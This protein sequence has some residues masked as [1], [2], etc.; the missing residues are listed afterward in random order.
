M[1]LLVGS[2]SDA[3][4]I[5]MV[6]AELRPARS[7]L[8]LRTTC[9]FAKKE[10]PLQA[11]TFYVVDQNSRRLLFVVESASNR[12][13]H[14]VPVR[15]SLGIR[16][17]ISLK[18]AFDLANIVQRRGLSDVVKR[19]FRLAGDHRQQAPDVIQLQ[20]LPERIYVGAKIISEYAVGQ[21][22]HD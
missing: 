6:T 22:T 3:G 12:V 7:W 5:S 20:V 16:P 2:T 10:K 11:G 17:T 14:I 15:T 19:G 1:T 18:H 13:Q 21:V 8:S 4:A 9:R